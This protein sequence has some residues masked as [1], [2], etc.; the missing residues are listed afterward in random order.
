[1]HI[2][3]EAMESYVMLTLPDSEIE[4]LQVHLFICQECRDRLVTVLNAAE[5]AATL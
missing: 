3:E 2:S 1:M 5:T 4:P